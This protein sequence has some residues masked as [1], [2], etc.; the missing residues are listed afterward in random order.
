[1]KNDA[2]IKRRP[3]Q[4]DRQG[5]IGLQDRLLYMAASCT[6][7]A[8]FRQVRD[9]FEKFGL[10]AISPYS[11]AVNLIDLDHELRYVSEER[12][13]LLLESR[14]SVSFQWWADESTDLYC[15]FLQEDEYSMMELHIENASAEVLE[16]L[17]EAASDLLEGVW[18]DRFYVVGDYWDLL[19][20]YKMDL[21]GLLSAWFGEKAED[22]N[23]LH[24][25]DEYGLG[26]DRWPAGTEEIRDDLMIRA[27]RYGVQTRK[28]SQEKWIKRIET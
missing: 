6:N 23:L 17:L 2:M 22:R 25:D 1:M 13:I 8:F 12:L 19:R 3:I 28:V 15:R 7:E 16:Q 27:K 11:N 4:A 24:S 14:Q 9:R 10:T 26:L 18:F 5:G 20:E 21:K